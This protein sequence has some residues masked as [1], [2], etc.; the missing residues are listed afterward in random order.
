[1]STI[2][3]KKTDCDE[4]YCHLHILIQFENKRKGEFKEDN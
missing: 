3:K 4:E 2:D 1:M